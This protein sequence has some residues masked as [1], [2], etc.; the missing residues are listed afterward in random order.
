VLPKH[1]P[2]PAQRPKF[3]VDSVLALL[4]KRTPV[5]SSA[6]PL[7]KIADNTLKGIGSQ[8]RSRSM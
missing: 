2:A 4:D 6:P 7:A 8:P 5:K 3:D 1:K